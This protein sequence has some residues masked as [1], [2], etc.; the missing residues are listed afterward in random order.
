MPDTFRLSS[1]LA[2]YDFHPAN[3]LLAATAAIASYGLMVAAL[4]LCRRRLARLQDDGRHRAVV[5]VLEKTL[6]STSMFT[7][8]ASALLIGMALLELPRPWDTQVR[9]LWFIGLGVQLALYLHKAIGVGVTRYFRARAGQRAG[10]DT[11]AHTLV[12]WAIQSTIWISLALAVLANLGINVSTFVASLGIGGIAVALAVQNI[13]GDLFA[14]L[15]IAVD[16]PFEVGD[17]ISVQG[18]S[19]TVEHVG[20]KTTRVRADSGEQIVIANSALLKDT[21][22][23]FKRMSQRRVQF[24]LR[25]DPTT[26]TAVAEAIPARLRAIVEAQDKVRF[27]RAHLKAIDQQAIEFEV[28]YYVLDPGFG[29]Y[30]DKQ[31]AVLLGAMQALEQM[32]VSMSLAPQPVQLRPVPRAAA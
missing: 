12:V 30:M 29:L 31:Q 3:A 6:A 15:S 26:S 18:F 5:D 10:A 17:A 19:G 9:H 28:V 4:C 14:S 7:I 8:A 16:K 25:V 13:L 1:L 27:D 24:A 21:V 22:R 11:V 32:K 20:L 23:N 2:Q